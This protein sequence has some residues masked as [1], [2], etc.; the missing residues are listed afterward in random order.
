[1]YIDADALPRP[2]RVEVEDG[3]ALETSG[4]RGG[5]GLLFGRE[6]DPEVRPRTFALVYESSHGVIGEA[7]RA[8]YK[9]YA[10]TDFDWTPPG[11]AYPIRV[12]YVEGPTAAWDTVASTSIRIVLEEQLAHD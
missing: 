2:S 8:H 9:L 10:F 1:M 4:S 12:I 11:G 7:V 5:A 6:P 3:A